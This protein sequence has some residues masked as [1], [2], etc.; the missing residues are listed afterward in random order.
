MPHRS[1]P[2]VPSLAHVPRRLPSLFAATFAVLAPLALL[3]NSSAPVNYRLDSGA[4]SVTAKVAFFGLGSKTA[5]F[6]KMS[7]AVTIVPDRP[8][9]ASI[10]VTFDAGALTASDKDTTTRLRGEKFFWVAKYPNVRFVGR[11]LKLTSKTSGTVTGQLTA[12]GITRAQTLKVTF[13]S[14]PASASGKPVSFTGTTRID[15]RQYGMKSYQLIV[16]NQVDIRLR[17]RMVPR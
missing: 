7:G 5:T 3:A 14:D 6:P 9:Q 2:A 8:Q 10:D 11:S 15:R 16:G 13:D 1:S 12:R 17:A 4:S